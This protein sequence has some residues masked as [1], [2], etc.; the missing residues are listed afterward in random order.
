[1]Q[2]HIY[3]LA[4]EY[5]LQH[6]PDYH[7][8][9]SYMARSTSDGAR[10]NVDYRKIKL[11]R[12]NRTDLRRTHKHIT[13]LT[14]LT[15]DEVVH[16]EVAGDVQQVPEAMI[17][18]VLCADVCR[19]D[20]GR[21]VVDGDSSL[22]HELSGEKETQRDVLRPRA[23]GAASQRVQRRCVV[24]TTALSRSPCRTLAQSACSSI[25]FFPSSPKPTPPA[26]P[27]WST[28]QSDLVDPT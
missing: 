16:V 21:D 15:V 17:V 18:H 2:Q 7:D 5:L 11:I 1:M 9:Q 28:L 4:K 24:G 13:R 3:A 14:E 23:E 25:T 8:F 22:R 10:P 12:T 6:K 27:P 20:V 19:V 26:P